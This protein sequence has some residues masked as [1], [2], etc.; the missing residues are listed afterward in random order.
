MT[1]GGGALRRL[2]VLLA[3]SGL[4]GAGFLGTGAGIIIGPALWAQ[5]TGRVV[6][7]TLQ[8][9]Q[10]TRD[11]RVYRPAAIAPRPGLVI[12]LHGADGSGLQ[13]ERTSRF[14][15][16]ADRLRWIAVYPNGVEDGWN[17]FGCCYHPGADDVA[18][19]AGIIDRLEASDSVDPA[20]V[21]VTGMSR[22]GMMAYRLAC[23]LSSR[24]AAIAPVAGN[25]ADSAGNVA[26]VDC[27]PD[28]PISVL[29]IHGSAD[30]EIPIE[31]GRSRVA[32]EEVAY[33]SLAAVIGKWRDLDGCSPSSSTGRSGSSTVSTWRCHGGSAV[34]MLV[35]SGAGHAWPGAPIV[36]PPWG[37]ARSLDASR[38]IADFFVAH[39]R[40]EAAA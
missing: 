5:M 38:V 8:Q 23:Q 36:N 28:H 24:L 35:V 17:P 19:V 18:F 37:P 21:Y 22:G 2:I 33:A 29:A 27:G 25:M 26:G 10:L 11:Y 34:E 7:E 14:D 31:G 12:V 9:G 20:R 30:P 39:P 3:A 16:Q 32:R 6:V 1:P 13:V 15:V 40:A 4:A